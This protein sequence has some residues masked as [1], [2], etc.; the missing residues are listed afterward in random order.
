MAE[1]RD[2]VDGEC[3]GAFGRLNE[4][5]G[6]PVN[7]S[8]ARRPRGERG[9][10]QGPCAYPGGRHGRAEGRGTLL[11]GEVARPT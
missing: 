6:K 2:V 3:R 7:L 10:A 11:A 5:R 9:V 1:V 8:T 4:R